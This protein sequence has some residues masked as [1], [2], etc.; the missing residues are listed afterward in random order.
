MKYAQCYATVGIVSTQMRGLFVHS[1]LDRTNMQISESGLLTP[2]QLCEG[3]ELTLISP[4]IPS[5][6]RCEWTFNNKQ[7]WQFRH[8][9]PLQL[10]LCLLAEYSPGSCECQIL[11]RPATEWNM[12]SASGVACD[13]TVCYIKWTSFRYNI[14]EHWSQIWPKSGSS[15]R[16]GQF[17]WFGLTLWL[18]SISW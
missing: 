8:A 12:W 3:A 6:L 13:R 7:W 11:S 16:W 2:S 4:F 5:L 10:I 17:F 9:K 18:I 1:M 15:S 14:F